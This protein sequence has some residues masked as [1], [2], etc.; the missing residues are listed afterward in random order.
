M[1]TNF[2]NNIKKLSAVFFTMIVIATAMVVS[3]CGQTVIDIKES[4][5]LKVALEGFDGNGTAT[6]DATELATEKATESAKEKTTTRK[7][8]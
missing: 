2:K 6:T 4:R 1:M 8:D 5:L 7:E 3:G